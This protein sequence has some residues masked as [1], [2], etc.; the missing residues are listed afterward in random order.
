MSSAWV[1]ATAC[2]VVDEA[3]NDTPVSIGNHLT[4]LFNCHDHCCGDNEFDWNTFALV[5]K[6]TD[7][8]FK[9]R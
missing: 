3:D 5:S 9:K 7:F 2:I 1:G 8:C 4:I 6:D